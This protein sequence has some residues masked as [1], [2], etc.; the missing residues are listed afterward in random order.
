MECEKVLARLWEYLDQELG[1]E[2]A[3]LIRNHLDG[4]TGCHPVYCCHGA[5]LRLL[6]R[7][8]AN[9]TAPNSLRIAVLVRL[10]T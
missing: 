8:R 6:A 3:G 7:Q 5:L 2:E 9:C 10:A 1:P 4:C